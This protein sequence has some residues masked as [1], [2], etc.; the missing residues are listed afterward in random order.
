[1]PACLASLGAYEIGAGLTSFV[2][3][4]HVGVFVISVRE[5]GSAWLTVIPWDDRPCSTQGF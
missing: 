5:L 3:V 2:D 4:L 1:M